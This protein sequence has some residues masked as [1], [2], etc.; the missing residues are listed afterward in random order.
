[1]PQPDEKQLPVS[2][3][4]PPEFAPEQIALFR[5]VLELMNRCGTPYVV[6]GAFALQKHTGIYRDTKDLD[7][8]LP[9][10]HVAA[11]LDCLV[12]DGFEYEITDPV[13]LAK[14]RRGDFFVDLITGMSNGAISVDESWVQRGSVLTV[15]DVPTRVL[16]AEELIAS[17]LFVTRRERFDGADIAHVLYGTRGRLDWDRLLHLVGAHWEVLLWALLLFRYVYPAQTD[18]VPR[19]IWDRLLRSFQQALAHPD[20]Q[21]QFRGSLID[22]KMFAIDVDEWGLPDIERQYRE[23]RPK[24]EAGQSAAAAALDP[25]RHC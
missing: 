24:I 20:P 9:V 19:E 15:F 13:W 18:Y 2:S 1:M 4:K 25:A 14:A 22:D 11:T 12:A 6:S 7:L 17:K 23:R 10:H 21:A 8:F 3:S 16:A 5:E